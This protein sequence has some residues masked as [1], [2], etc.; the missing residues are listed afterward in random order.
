[1]PEFDE[2]KI[3]VGS[4]VKTDDWNSFVDEL[5]SEFDV[6]INHFTKLDMVLANDNL[7]AS[8]GKPT[9]ALHFR[10]G[11]SYKNSYITNRNNFVDNGTRDNKDLIIS[12]ANNIYLQTGDVD[13]NHGKNTLTIHKN[14]NVG[15]GLGTSKPEKILHIHSPNSD[16]GLKITSAGNSQAIHLHLAKNKSGEYGYFHLGGLTKLRGN[17][18]IS[19]FEGSLGIGIDQPKNKLHLFSKIDKGGPSP[20]KVETNWGY[21]DIGARNDGYA[22][23][24]TDLP[25]YYF[26]KNIIV[27]GSIG[28][29]KSG[30]GNMEA[31]LVTKKLPDKN[32]P[33]NHNI[34]F[35]WEYINKRVVIGG[36]SQKITKYFLHIYIDGK[37]IHT[38]SDL[39]PLD[40]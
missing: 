7:T 4:T 35:G 8:T 19:S 30:L 10:G 24:Y 1:M 31:K 3:D 36:F 32:G 17:G 9:S 6:K 15:I 22:H 40:L 33:T 14:G 25:R 20:L 27:N 11:D 5:R 34:S 16:N 37:K 26:N 28:G 38:V 18:K 12:S 29:Y 21:M 39:K 23:F 13:V 2:L